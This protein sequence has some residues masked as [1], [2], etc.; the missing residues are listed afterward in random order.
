MKQQD[1]QR[2]EPCSES[3]PARGA[4]I[5]TS[6][7][8]AQRSS[9]ASPPARGAWIE[10]VRMHSLFLQVESPPARGAWIETRRL[11]PASARPRVAPRAGGVD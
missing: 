9:T 3:P 7:A 6:S 2:K 11:R 4:W 8:A 5:E 10:T 1:L